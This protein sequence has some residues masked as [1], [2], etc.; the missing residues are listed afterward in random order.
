MESNTL[1]EVYSEA[2]EKLPDAKTYS[3]E[4]CTI[5]VNDGVR[6]CVNVIF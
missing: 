6:R 3:G 5:P 4:Q 1:N 2:Y